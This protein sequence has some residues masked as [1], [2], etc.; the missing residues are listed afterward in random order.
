M[1]NKK[2]PQTEKIKK[3]NSVSSLKKET[4]RKRKNFIVYVSD[5]TFEKLIE[6]ESLKR[7]QWQNRS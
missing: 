1:R 6:R 4:D 7:Y 2:E 3:R 5:Y